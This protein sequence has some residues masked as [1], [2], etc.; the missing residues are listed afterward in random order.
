MMTHGH[1]MFT[2]C[3]HKIYFYVVNIIYTYILRCSRLRD[4]RLLVSILLNAG[5]A[6]SNGSLPP[7]L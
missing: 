7:G 5:L 6:E 3:E 1:V 4:I 2:K